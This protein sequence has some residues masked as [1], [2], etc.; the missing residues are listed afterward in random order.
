MYLNIESNSK[1][2]KAADQSHPCFL[3]LGRPFGSY[4]CVLKC[5]LNFKIYQGLSLC[6]FPNFILFVQ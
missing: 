3:F 6:G 2:I 5:L 1:I 4:C